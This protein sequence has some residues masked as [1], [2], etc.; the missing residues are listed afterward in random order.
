MGTKSGVDSTLKRAER[1]Q[2]HRSKTKV[3]SARFVRNP[4]KYLHGLLKEKKSG[5][6]V[7]NQL[8]SIRSYVF[9]FIP[10]SRFLVRFL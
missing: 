6:N 9:Y 2:K 10:T 8:A 7:K 5:K 1:I 4:F 3:K